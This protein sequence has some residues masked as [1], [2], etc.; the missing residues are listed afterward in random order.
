MPPRPNV[1]VKG[2]RTSE[3]V[4]IWRVILDPPTVP[5]YWAGIG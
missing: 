3:A 5:E 4:A 2:P 1:R